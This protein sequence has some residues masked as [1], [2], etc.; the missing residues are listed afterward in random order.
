M[1][2]PERVFNG[3]YPPDDAAL[4]QPDDLKPVYDAAYARDVTMPAKVW[5][6]MCLAREVF[7]RTQPRSH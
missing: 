4:K 2:W 5:A 3:K 7:D 1:P 6:D